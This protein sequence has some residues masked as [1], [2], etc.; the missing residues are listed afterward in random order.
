M[1]SRILSGVFFVLLCAGNCYGQVERIGMKG[2]A[3]FSIFAQLGNTLYATSGDGL[4]FYRSTDEGDTWSFFIDGLPVNPAS[5][6]K[7][8]RT[9]GSKLH[10]L[11][12]W[13]K[14]G[15]EYQM[16]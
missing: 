3:D 2:T 1:K 16:M 13:W 11:T 15:G 4:N 7:E 5:Y 8:L 12:F 10:M 14:P 6:A 9:D